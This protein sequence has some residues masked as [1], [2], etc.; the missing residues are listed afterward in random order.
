MS[1]ALLRSILNEEQYNAATSESKEILTLACAGSGKSTTLAFRIARLIEKGSDPKNIVAFTFTEKAAE[2]IK[3]RVSSALAKMG[4]APM[5]VGAMYIGT[6][7]AFCLDILGQIDAKYRQFDVL[8]ENQLII[9]LM[10]RYYDLK[11]Q[12]IRAIR[13][14]KY[15]ETIREISNA[16]NLINHERIDLITVKKADQDL[17]HIL[18]NLDKSLQAN[19]YIDFSL[20]I[21]LV[22]DALLE[23]NQVAISAIQSIKHLLVDEYQDINPA[24]EALICELHRYTDTL[25]VVGDDDQSIYGWRGADVSNILD[26]ENR[27]PKCSKFTISTNYRSTQPIVDASDKFIKTELGALRIQK[28]PKAVVHNGPSD[29]GNYWFENRNDE[30]E[31]IAK[32]IKS[33]LG[34]KYEERE[35]EIRGLTPADFAILMRSTRTKEANEEPRHEAYTKSLSKMKIPYSLESGG[36][37]FDRPQVAA[38]KETFELLR[39]DSPTR[40]IARTHFD[41]NIIIKFPNANFTVFSEVLSLWGRLIHAPISGTRRR[42]YPQQLVYDLLNSFGIEQTEF[43]DGVMHDI[44]VFSRIMQDVEMVY[45]SIDSSRRFQDILNFLS[46][47][48][49]SGYDTST[50][51]ILSKPDTVTVSTVHKV[52]GLE[53][54]VVFVVDVENNGRFPGRIRGYSGWLPH[55][56]LSNPLSRHAYQSSREEEARLFYTAITRSER[57]LYITGSKKLPGGKR[58][59]KPSPFSQ[60]LVHKEISTDSSDYPKGITKVEQERRINETILPTSFSDIKYYLKCPKDYQLRKI[61][62]FNPP[63]PELFGFGKTMHAGISR[64]HQNYSEKP[65]SKIDVDQ[66]VKDTFYLKHVPRSQDPVRHPGPYERALDS[67][68]E[69]SSNY[70]D[71]YKSDFSK[72]KQIEARFE[73]PVE[74]ALVS[75]SIDLIVRVNGE[76]NIVDANIIDFKTMEGGFIPE[77][78]EELEWTELSLQVQLYAKAARDVLGENA[79]TGSV[80]L[81][82]DNKRINI[83]IDDDAINASV[84]NVEWAVDRIISGDFPARPSD[85]KCELCDFKKICSK[86]PEEFRTE[87]IPPEIHIPGDPNKK[88]ARVFS[89]FSE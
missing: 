24:Q 75:G 34:C 89:D 80:H 83:P 85:N 21:R 53:F 40:E 87:N 50:D 74:Q 32:R 64:I 76:N 79:S 35:G 82:K 13:G 30:A 11:I 27:F 25:F 23:K 77:T 39:D 16:W 86:N 12:E 46:N 26:F 28:D 1:D 72:N 69:M 56:I 58:D 68:I 62:G 15:F 67:A 38:L 10:S 60:G 42:V 18:E 29:F 36:S 44:G 52:K 37:V 6:I 33:L 41:Q 9:Y 20:I 71:S 47:V 54:P 88:L 31:W 61:F 45:M 5:I 2:S 59:L 78:N 4:I 3:N 65:P 55:E 57:F 81:L 19:Q 84:Q 49:E 66:L 48:A 17:G 7:H 70:V 73:V 22:V 43:D 14:S 51:D 63:I 8:D